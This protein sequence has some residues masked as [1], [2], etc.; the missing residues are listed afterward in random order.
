MEFYEYKMSTNGLVWDMGQVWLA[1]T[2]PH[3]QSSHKTSVSLKQKGV[4]GLNTDWAL[5][6]NDRQD[7][8]ELLNKMTE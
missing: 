3:N 5:L 2:P 1:T 4:C 6:T 7:K 8:H